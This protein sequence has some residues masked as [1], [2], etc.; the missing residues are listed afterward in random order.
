V[1]AAVAERSETARELERA[2]AGVLVAPDDPA[3]L[4][5]SI[6]EF[7]L[8]HERA[9]KLGMRGRAYAEEH[10]TTSAVLER[11]EEFVRT[12]S[13]GSPPRRKRRSTKPWDASDP[14]P[15]LIDA[16]SATADPR[17]SI[18][19]VSYNCLA[20]LTACLE[21][22]AADEDAPPLEVIVVDNASEDGTV[23]AITERFPWVRVI[24][25]HANVGFAHAMNQGIESAGGGA[26]LALNPDTVVP[27]G[28]ISKALA[29]LE[30][31]PDVGMLGVKL[32]RPDG[33]FDHACKRGF[34]TVSSAFYYFVGLSR[35]RPRSARFAQ[36][37]AGELGEDETGTVDA[38]N[39]A[40][41][42]VKRRAVDDVGPMDERYWLYAEDIDWCHRFWEKGW[43]V[44]Y[45]PD[46]RVIHRKG[47]SS[48]D[49]RS[50]DLNRAFHRSMWL[51][52]E[53]HVAPGQPKV[54]SGLVWAGVWTKF[55][56][57]ALANTLRRPP[58][59]D[60]SDERAAADRSSVDTRA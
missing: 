60:W 10:L 38:I 1:I 3:A 34:P 13:R 18:L 43:K 36:Y 9:E 17:V 27:A 25:N 59:H 2:G 12:V 6:T 24:A 20:T 48:G 54:V 23:A 45:W 32:H 14:T 53:K 47:G 5:A 29:E 35:L 41:M 7:K 49:I 31:H 8:D 57:S 11:Y 39:G 33:T 56:L 51:F 15:R 37:T 46:V 52:Y 40:F 28:A 58:V 50:W 42:L 26:L 30:R 4:A 55:G 21:S 16:R 22:L 44:L 19:I